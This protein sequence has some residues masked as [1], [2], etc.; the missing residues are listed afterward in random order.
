MGSELDNC[1]YDDDDLP[2]VAFTEDELAA[3]VQH[4]ARTGNPNATSSGRRTASWSQEPIEDEG[5]VLLSPS[6]APL[7]FETYALARDWAKVNLG[8]VIMRASDGHGFEARPASSGRSTNEMWGRRHEMKG[9]AP[10]LHE[11]MS[12]S[13]SNDYN[14]FIQPFNRSTWERELS[15]LRLAQL[16]RLR[17]LVAFELQTGREY[18]RRLYAEMRRFP[19]MRYGEYGQELFEK[20]NEI[21]EGALADIDTRLTKGRDI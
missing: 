8:G 15:E 12:K 13:G 6:P 11:V 17:V 7:R 14:L 20:L 3:G 9:I 5:D 19:K 2:D 18:L 10:H 21:L 4:I 16:S 1:D